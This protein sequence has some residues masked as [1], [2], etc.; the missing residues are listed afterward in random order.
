VL[1]I[2]LSFKG[3]HMMEALGKPSGEVPDLYT[4]VSKKIWNS[5]EDYFGIEPQK[6]QEAADFLME[7]YVDTVKDNLRGQCTKGHSCKVSS[8]EKLQMTIDILEEQ[9]G[10][11]DMTI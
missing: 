9:L 11:I 5:I 7:V 2:I 6:A 8:L 10:G 4:E 1:N 3:M